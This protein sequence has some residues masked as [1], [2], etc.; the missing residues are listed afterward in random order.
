MFVDNVYIF[1]DLSEFAMTVRM[2][3]TDK[4]FAPYLVANLLIH[5]ENVI[6]WLTKKK[7]C[8]RVGGRLTYYPFKKS[9]H[10]FI[11]DGRTKPAFIA[12]LKKEGL[13]DDFVAVS[14]YLFA[15]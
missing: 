11:A 13:Y 6:S 12:A 15:E 8:N 2:H 4:K 10:E 14:A 3:K 1:V 5:V 9:I 7:I